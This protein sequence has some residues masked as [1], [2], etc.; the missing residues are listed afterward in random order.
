[1]YKQLHDDRCACGYKAIRTV[2]YKIT[3]VKQRVICDIS[4]PHSSEGLLGLC[5]SQR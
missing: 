2:L 3:E 1:V 5:F 4:C